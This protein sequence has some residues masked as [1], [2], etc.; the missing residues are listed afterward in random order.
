[1]L[2]IEC[3][4]HILL[5]IHTISSIAKLTP[6]ARSLSLADSGVTIADHWTATKRALLSSK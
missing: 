2:S 5:L 6:R 1:M 3:K 4:S